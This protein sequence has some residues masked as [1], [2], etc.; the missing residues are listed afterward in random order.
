MAFKE[1]KGL[2]ESKGWDAVDL[3]DPPGQSGE[4]KSIKDVTIKEGEEKRIILLSSEP[5]MVA[6]HSTFDF[7][8]KGSRVIC[9]KKHGDG[10]CPMCE[11]GNFAGVQGIFLGIDCGQIT[12]QGGK[13]TKLTG[14]APST[15]KN[16]GKEYNFLLR[17]V[18]MS[19]GSEKKPGYLK[20]FQRVAAISCQGDTSLTVWDVSRFGRQDP[21]SGSLWTFVRKLSGKDELGRILK[22]YGAEAEKITEL[23]AEVGSTVESKLVLPEVDY[24]C[25]LTGIEAP[26]RKRH[27]AQEPSSEGWGRGPSRSIDD[28]DAELELDGAARDE[29]ASIMYDDPAGLDTDVSEGEL[30]VDGDVAIDDKDIPF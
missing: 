20:T 19:R 9:L 8:K 11:A 3:F 28:I 1:L 24:L 22:T 18:A 5:I 17:L 6:R 4:E 23:L 29:R 16:A 14:W 27:N 12:R 10:F 2:D 25:R 26:D 15:G 7:D 21:S 30:V 13:V